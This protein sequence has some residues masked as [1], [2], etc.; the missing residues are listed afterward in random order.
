MEHL[1]VLWHYSD[2]LYQC[3]MLQ[4]VCRHF[5]KVVSLFGNPVSP[6]VCKP[7]FCGL[8]NVV[9]G[10]RYLFLVLCV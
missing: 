8:L 9:F 4:F 10:Q 1:E 7:A 2:I 5:G 3:N 6:F